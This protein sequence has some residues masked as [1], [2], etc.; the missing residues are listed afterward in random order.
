MRHSH[1]SVK[2]DGLVFCRAAYLRIPEVSQRKWTMGLEIDIEYRL[3]FIFTSQKQWVPA[4]CW[5]KYPREDKTTVHVSWVRN[6]PAL[7]LL[8]QHLCFSTT[9]TTQFL[10]AKAPDKS[11]KKIKNT[12]WY[13]DMSHHALLGW[14]QAVP[15]TLWRYTAERLHFIKMGFSM[16]QTVQG[17][18]W[19]AMGF[20]TV[21]FLPRQVLLT[22]GIISINHRGKRRRGLLGR[23][24][25]A[26][27]QQQQQQKSYLTRI[28]TWKGMLLPWVFHGRLAV[29][30]KW[31]CMEVT[32]SGTPEQINAEWTACSTWLSCVTALACQVCSRK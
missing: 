30:I 21:L 20:S 9:T 8:L 26:V 19:C 18:L 4:E 23:H 29:T 2:P 14:H 32:G 17:Q 24:D 6:C 5:S 1:Y 27:E 31:L 11:K 22:H 7:S 13:V 3:S 16:E 15:V 25:S 28:N 10:T 12:Y